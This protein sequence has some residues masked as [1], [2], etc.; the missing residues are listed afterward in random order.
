[1]KKVFNIIF[2]LVFVAGSF[3]FSHVQA[4]DISTESENYLDMDGLVMETPTGYY[5]DE[6]QSMSYGDGLAN[7]Y[8]FE[9][10]M[11]DELRN[12]RHRDQFFRDEL[13]P[14]WDRSSQMSE[15]FPERPAMHGE[16]D[17][18]ELSSNREFTPPTAESLALTLDQVNS[19]DCSTVTDVPEIE[20]EALVALYASTN[21]A[22]WNNRDNW[23]ETTTASNWYGVIIENKHVRELGLNQNNL[24]G[25]LPSEIGD[26]ESLRKLFLNSNFLEGS[27]PNDLWTLTEMQTL[28]LGW[29]QFTG[30]IPSQIGNLTK[31]AYLNLSGNDLQG[32]IP[33]ELWSLTQMQS[34]MLSN[35][36]LSGSL[37]PEI[38]NLNL[39][40]YL[41]LGSNE[42]TGD[43]PPLLGDLTNLTYLFLHNN[44]LSGQIPDELGDLSNL[45][46]LNLSLNQLS[47]SI[48]VGLENLTKLERLNL[49]GNQLEGSIPA[50]LGSLSE[51]IYLNLYGNRLSGPIP[52]ELGNLSNL[53]SL[54]LKWNQ[55]SGNIPPELGN[56]SSLEYLDMFANSFTGPIPKDLGNLANLRTLDLTWTGLSGPIPKEIGELSNLVFLQLAGNQLDGE[57]PAE[58]G[59]L[60]NLGWLDLGA[61]QLEGE[62]PV[63]LG[64]LTNLGRLILSGNDL[65]GSIPPELGN[66][67]ELGV[68]SLSN[69][70]LSGD[71]PDNLTNLEDLCTPSDNCYLIW[72][73]YGLDLGYNNLNTT[74]LSDDLATFLEWKNPDWYLTQ[75]KSETIEDGGQ[76]GTIISHDGE[77]TINVPSGAVPDG[78]EFTFAPQPHPNHSTGDLRFGNKSFRLTAQDGQGNPVTNFD[79]PV[80]ITIIYGELPSWIDEPTLQL[81]NWNEDSDSW[82]DAAC[83]DYERN[84][85]E[86]WF[87]VDICHLSEF[88]VLGDPIDMP[89]FHIYLPLILR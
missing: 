38:S 71:I 84:L 47:G 63:E 88:A 8:D 6:F 83:G 26:L 30:N 77:T 79:P 50:Q 44:Q 42:L 1:M 64:N 52:A 82:V 73:Q 34:L 22:N 75:A 25:L 85:E 78:T 58:L 59:N 5:W 7:D 11:P 41:A 12:R 48:P 56:L 45:V 14:E 72:D 54:D 10:E 27:I 23:L 61:N 89:G 46:S 80:N 2:C 3:L 74:G 18:L 35:C 67:H 13:D 16:L 40:W 39:L 28:Q 32:T 43:I 29:N 49:F 55:L 57:I 9:S 15:I 86:N 60:S 62:I 70:N 68:L 69:N 53:Q 33:N 81:Y 76:G 65:V 66:L 20:C 4:G 51:L 19:F 17:E 31:M 37:P 21:G 24:S 36:G 87:S